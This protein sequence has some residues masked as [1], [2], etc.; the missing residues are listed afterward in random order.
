MTN[1]DRIVDVL[2]RSGVYSNLSHEGAVDFLAG[3]KK[4][5]YS[6][7]REPFLLSPWRKGYDCARAVM[8]TGKWCFVSAA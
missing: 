5:P 1:L 7:I 4:A 3:A 8:E 6:L 2:K